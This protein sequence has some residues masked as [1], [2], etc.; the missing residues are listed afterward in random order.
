MNHVG[1][2]LFLCSIIVLTLV[3][4]VGEK[5]KLIANRMTWICIASIVGLSIMN[6]W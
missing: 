5:D 2:S 1:Y 3:G 6:V 4:S